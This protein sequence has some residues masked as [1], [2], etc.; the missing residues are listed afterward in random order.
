ML[1]AYRDGSALAL[2]SHACSLISRKGRTQSFPPRGCVS[3]GSGLLAGTDLQSHR[4]VSIRLTRLAP[5]RDAQPWR[6]TYE[7]ETCPPA[8][9]LISGLFS[10][11]FGSR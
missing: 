10:V 5:T 11:I 6:L 3:L 8:R 7:W 9:Q 1:A 4:L 2:L